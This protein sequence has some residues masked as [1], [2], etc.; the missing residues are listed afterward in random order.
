MGLFDRF[1]AKKE[2]QKAREMAKANPTPKTTA[3]FA[4]KLIEFK[5]YDNALAVLEMGAKAFPNSELLQSKYK[6]LKR[7]KYQNEIKALKEQIEKNQD[8]VAYAKLADIYVKIGEEDR[9]I[10]ICQ[11]GC[12]KFPDY[13]GNHLILGKLRWERFRRNIQVRDGVKAVE[14]FEYVAQINPKNYKV[15]YQLARIYVELGYPQKAIE[16][17]QV[18]LQHHPEDENCQRLLRRAKLLPPSSETDLEYLFQDLVNKRPEVLKKQGSAGAIIERLLKDKA[19]LQK[20]L[21]EFVKKPGLL[22]LAIFNSEGELKLSHITDPKLKETIHTFLP[23]MIKPTQNCSLRMDIGSLQDAKVK[24]KKGWIWIKAFGG[25]VFVF[26]FTSQAKSR[27][28]ESFLDNF[29]EYEIYR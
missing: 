15:L 17:L 22:A 10:E 11:A 18:I 6:K 26:M 12:E 24:G 27:Q 28:V 7:L 1:R 3:Y 9:A 29:F 19:S 23:R 14:H 8:R 4:D 2:I 20:K 16:K 13:E 5:E 25:G 21:G